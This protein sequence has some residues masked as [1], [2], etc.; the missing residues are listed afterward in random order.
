MFPALSQTIPQAALGVSIEQAFRCLRR[1]ET[2]T[3]S[4]RRCRIALEVLQKKI[5]AT[6]NMAWSESAPKPGLFLYSGTAESNIDRVTAPT[7]MEDAWTLFEG[8]DMFWLDNA[9]MDPNDVAA[10]S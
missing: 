3:V 2:Y 8:M 4:A 5:T 6:G 7:G 1:Y 9:L 10:W